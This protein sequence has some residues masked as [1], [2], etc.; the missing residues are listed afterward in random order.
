MSETLMIIILVVV[1]LCLVGVAVAVFSSGSSTDSTSALASAPA[2]KDGNVLTITENGASKTETYRMREGYMIIPDVRGCHVA[3]PAGWCSEMGYSKDEGMAFIY[4]EQLGPSPPN[5]LPCEEGA[6][7]C[8]DKPNTC[9]GGG[10]D[11]AFTE[12]Y[13]SEGTLIS[14]SNKKGEEL[15][16]K[17]ADDAWAGKWKNWQ[18]ARGMKRDLDYKG[19]KIILKKDGPGGAKAGNELTLK[20]ATTMGVPIMYF[21]ALLLFMY[22]AGEPRPDKI[23]LAAKG[24]R[25]GFRMRIKGTEGNKQETA[26]DQPSS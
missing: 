16:D 14:I 24:A 13:N 2:P 6:E 5:N 23:V 11:C 15:L 9:P 17:M 25:H 8:E 20:L 10:Y 18:F 26:A 7:M 12:K 19:G 3:E 1:V 4:D 21:I 22:E